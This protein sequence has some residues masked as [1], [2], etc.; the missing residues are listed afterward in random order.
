MW[1]DVVAL[2]VV[3]A[4]ITLAARRVLQSTRRA[5]DGACGDCQG[6]AGESVTVLSAD[7]L[8]VFSPP[9]GPSRP[10]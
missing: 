5:G 1:Q 2:T 4:T 3:A 7:T 10:T 9:G 8:R 6:C